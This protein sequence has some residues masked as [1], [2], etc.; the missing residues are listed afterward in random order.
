MLIGR[1]TDSSLVLV[2]E[3]TILKIL[4]S[5]YSCSTARSLIHS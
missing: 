4:A 3:N 1:A 5:Y 2:E